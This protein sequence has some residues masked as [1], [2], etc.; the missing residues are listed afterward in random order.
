MVAER[1]KIFSLTEVKKM[2]K[3]NVSA[4]ISLAVC[5]VSSLALAA[6]VFTMPSFFRWFYSFFNDGSPSSEAVIKTVVTAFYICVP[7]A[8]A[9]LFMMI[10]ILVNILNEKVFIMQNVVLFRFLSWCCYAVL[11]ITVIF[12]L[13]YV[14][15]FVIA[16]AMGV[17]GTLLRVIKNIMQS[18][19]ELREENDLTI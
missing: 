14:P 5:M 9:A 16:F 12:G 18:A 3:R 1:N 6:L 7:F 10:K 19:V 2:I 4:A 8:A 15:L 13:K 17:V 11:I